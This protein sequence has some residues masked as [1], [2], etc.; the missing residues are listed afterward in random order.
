M[1][2]YQFELKHCDSIL[3]QILHAD[4]DNQIDRLCCL[5]QY[6]CSKA[7]YLKE[8]HEVSI[9]LEIYSEPTP[10][11]TTRSKYLQQQTDLEAWNKQ[12]NIIEQAINGK[13]WII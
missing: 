12:L 7:D 8:S 1:N 10:F 6:C 3:T 9:N 13:G 11:Q 4:T 5:G 2:F